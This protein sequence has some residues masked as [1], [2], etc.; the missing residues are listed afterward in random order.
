MFAVGRMF[1]RKDMGEDKALAVI[2]F[3]GDVPALLDESMHLI[4]LVTYDNPITMVVERAIKI[5][6]MEGWTIEDLLT[7]HDGPFYMDLS[8]L[9]DRQEEE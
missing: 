5:S 8:A 4:R 2:V 1:V 3:K 6:N 9:A 7:S